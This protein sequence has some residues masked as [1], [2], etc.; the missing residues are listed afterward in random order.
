MTIASAVT[1][2]MKGPQST[3]FSDG[4][5]SQTCLGL[6]VVTFAYARCSAPSGTVNAAMYLPF[7]RPVMWFTAASLWRVLQAASSG[8]LMAK[9]SLL[10]LDREPT[11][12]VHTGIDQETSMERNYTV[13]LQDGRV[14]PGPERIAA[15]CRFITAIERALG[16]SDEVA[17]TYR[18]WMTATESQAD[19]MD[20]TT[21]ALAV[22]WP[23]AYQL[24]SHAGLQ[25]VY[26]VEDA[27][28]EIKLART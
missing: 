24:A 3:H 20:R 1:G 27:T 6:I 23:Q 18:A 15:E 21:A 25:G 10:T 5:P 26:G 2:S 14:L 8:V 4:V 22:R 13:A 16:D 17:T 19:T 7:I 12:Y 28:F 11:L 9:Q